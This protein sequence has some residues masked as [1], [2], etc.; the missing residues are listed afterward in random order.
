MK[1][2]IF[3]VL[4]LF[5]VL[6]SSCS[7]FEKFELSIN[8]SEAPSSIEFDVYAV[9]FDY[10]GVDIET[11]YGGHL[12]NENL[13]FEAKV[14]V[15]TDYIYVAL[16]YDDILYYYD[17]EKI[18]DSKQKID[19]KGVWYR[20]FLYNNFSNDRNSL[21]G[22]LRKD[23]IKVVPG[24][25]DCIIRWEFD[26]S[27]K[28]FDSI[29]IENARNKYYKIAYV[30][31]QDCIVNYDYDYK[32][33]KESFESGVYKF[34]PSEYDRE[35]IFK[36]EKDTVYFTV[37]PEF[38]FNKFLN[39]KLKITINE[40]SQNMDDWL[41]FDNAVPVE[42]HCFYLIKNENKDSFS[43]KSAKLYSYDSS[44]KKI[45]LAYVLLY[46]CINSYEYFNE[47]FYFSSKNKVYCRESVSGLTSMIYEG[48]ASSSSVSFKMLD[49]ENM[50][51]LELCNNWAKGFIYNLRTKN[52]SAQKE[53]LF[54]GS[55]FVLVPE[56]RTVFYVKEG[57]SPS[58]L[59]SISWNQEMTELSS[60]DSSVH[61][62]H[63]GPVY[64]LESESRLI[65]SDCCI[66][67]NLDNTGE[68]FLTGF[69]K[70]FEESSGI[71][72]FDDLVITENCFYTLC[73]RDS[74]TCLEKRSLNAPYNRFSQQ[75]YSDF[76]GKKLYV[77]E[78]G[79]LYVIGNGTVKTDD[80]KREVILLELDLN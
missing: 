41:N 52:C 34:L 39:P 63:A 50:L 56:L 4:I 22:I 59:T 7:V 31:G 23:F 73:Y 9:A 5:C 76:I 28:Y 62:S 30:S 75:V 25:K 68:S 33:I 16:V 20:S 11:V 80:G 42:N 14:P 69:Q 45:E 38:Y 17:Y 1:K 70:G 19:A 40:V 13:S 65:T 37:R 10:K 71:Q 57:V 8:I 46:D 51:V 44:S 66:F 27:K 36:A 21:T 74:K 61:E 35:L 32:T 79:Q 58:K 47:K 55:Q 54:F 78:T 2:F 15:T 48:A 12:I 18:T 64:Y 3:T 49:D 53:N 26:G 24:Q 29:K 67:E 72:Y 60:R 77:S 43:N 6:F